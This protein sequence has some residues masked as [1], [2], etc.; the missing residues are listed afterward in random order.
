MSRDEWINTH[1]MINVNLSKN[2][3]KY[4]SL[5][6]LVIPFYLFADDMGVND[7][8]HIELESIHVN[9]ITNS[10]WENQ[11]VEKNFYDNPY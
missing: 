7:D 9:E 5:V 10:A 3:S 6:F 2:L 8:Y 11:I 4:L 1:Y